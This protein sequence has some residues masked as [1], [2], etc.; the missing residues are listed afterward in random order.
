MKNFTIGTRL[1]IGFGLISLLL[2]AVI[3][4]GIFSIYNSGGQLENVDRIGVLSGNAANLLLNLKK[5]DDSIKALML[6]G[7]PA[8]RAKLQ[9][10]IEEYRE[11]YRK[12]LEF[13]EKK[14]ITPDG[15]KL[16]QALKS[17][18]DAGTE[19]NRQLIEA[20]AAGDAARYREI[21]SGSG[22]SCIAAYTKS[23]D[24]L[25][26]Y[27]EKRAHLRVESARGVGRTAML[28]MAV[29][30]CA[31]LA[32]SI[33]TALVITGSV[34]KPLDEIVASIIDMTEGN[35]C[36]R[37]EYRGADELGQLSAHFNGFAEKLQRIM[38]ELN[39]DAERVASAS[40][41][42]MATAQQMAEGSEEVVAQ[43]STVATAGEEMAATSSD[44][45]NNCH[46]AADGAARANASAQEGSG[47]VQS[48]IAVMESVADRV[49]SAAQAVE[50][51]GS[52]SDQIGAIVGT[53][54]D[55]ADQTNLLAL[56]AAIE[57]ARAGE[58]GRGFAV[59]ADEVR[60]LAERTTR[61]TKEISEMI[62]SIQSE[63]QN[64]VSVM[65]EGNREVERGT[66]EAAR[67]GRALAEILE[68]INA[69]TMQA[70]Q[71]ATAAEEQTATTGEISSNM[72]SIT[73]V[74][75][76]TAQGAG[77]TF[78]AARSLSS[79]SEQLQSIVRQF[80]VS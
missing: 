30:G 63:T 70:N 38:L 31:A 71:I 50:S 36:R 37:V 14:T 25:L 29:F 17:S 55:I 16:V 19:L 75:Q 67:S 45:A 32:L 44:I 8:G 3:G 65:E 80:K 5:I 73:V 2:V 60:A 51:L 58:Q 69:V 24:D 42:L 1:M 23:A 41:Q 43:A 26:T 66:G 9:G 18:L 22:E 46:L 40:V 21:M 78:Q 77:E 49:R 39:N 64:A 68:Q 72:Q 61:A 11:G 33:A 10:R 53:I 20:A 34:K 6:E 15:K 28:V 59:V 27:Y 7:D 35:L 48:T 79:M 13:I 74:V 56:N 62:R 57:A 54:E 4:T 47:V 12:N 76:K 52:R